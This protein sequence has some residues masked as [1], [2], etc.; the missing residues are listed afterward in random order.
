MIRPVRFAFNAQTAVNN[1]FQKV[2]ESDVQQQA[3]QEFDDLVQILRVNQI[4]VTVINDTELPHTPDSIFPNNWLSFHAPDQLV[5]YPMFANNRRFER[6]AA[7]LEFARQSGYT[8]VLDLTSYENEN[9]FLEGTG[10][11]VLDR[12]NKIAYACLSART[13]LA[14]LQKY[15]EEM[16]Y[17]PCTFHAFDTRQT[18]IYHT[19]VMMCIAKE[20]AVVC[21]ESIRDSMERKQLEK[22]LE[23]TRKQVIEISRA[24]VDTFAGNML[25]V[26]NQKGQRL[27][28]MSSQ[29]FQSLTTMQVQKLTLQNKIIHSPL[30]TIERHG[31]GSARCM[32]AEVFFQMNSRFYD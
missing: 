26:Q 19:N 22:T 21:L 18:P 32:I 7:V 24:Q 29:A 11:M 25:Q 12:E 13:H 27:M 6:K 2:G 9:Q 14:V 31:G 4:D 15:C 16:N 23:A 5:L 30:Y 17:T 28:V 3:L 20:L 1:A 10:S 8:Q